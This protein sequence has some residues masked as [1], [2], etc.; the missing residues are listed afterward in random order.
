M[1]DL[2]TVTVTGHGTATVVPDCAVVR[3][4]VVHRAP[5][6][7]DALAGVSATAERAVGVAK[8]RDLLAGSTGINVWPWHDHE[9]KA[10]GFEARHALSVRCDSVEDA[11]SLLSALADE[12]GDALVV[13]G[14]SL[15]VRDPSDV[16]TAATEAAYD[17][18]RAHAAHLAAL[19]GATLGEVVS[20]TDTADTTG[21]GPTPVALAAAGRGAALEPG[22]TVV[23]SS[24]TVSWTLAGA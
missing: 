15:D 6:V 2:R 19:A 1:S 8:D 13:E 21:G 16:R 22:E 11:G 10:G 24:V 4:A 18:A 14:V 17:D 12:V 20:L 5:G 23:R 9:G 3:V 7:A